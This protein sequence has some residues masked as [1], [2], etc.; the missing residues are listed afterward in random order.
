MINF[1]D[2]FHTKLAKAARKEVSA[3]A[4]IYNGKMLFGRRRDVNKFTTPC[5]H[6]EEGETPVQGAA[7]ELWEESG[8][9]A[10]EKDLKFLKTIKKPDGYIIHGYRLDLKSRP[11]TTMKN[12]PDNEVYRWMFINSKTIPDKE[13]HVPRNKGNVLLEALENDN[14]KKAAFYT[15]SELKKRSGEILKGGLGDNKPDKD[16]NKKQIKE[17][18]KTELEHTP[19]RQLAKEIAKD[20]LTEIPDYYSRLSKM[21]KSANSRAR[22][23]KHYLR[24]GKKEALTNNNLITFAR[25][26][27]TSSREKEAAKKVKIMCGDHYQALLDEKR[28]DGV[29]RGRPGYAD[30]FSKRLKEKLGQN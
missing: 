21:E 2:G 7:R 26:K 15:K 28:G 24:K 9:K 6:L 12:D 20:H 16:F 11:K 22:I 19:N 1:I 30:S 17:G 10:K 25:D 4:V 3:V 29:D 23:V 18:I 13:L 14:E 27:M 5:G 8:I